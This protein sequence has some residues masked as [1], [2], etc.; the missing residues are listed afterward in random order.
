[1]QIHVA[2]PLCFAAFA[3]QPTAIL[4]TLTMSSKRDE[5]RKSLLEKDGV[6]LVVLS[7]VRS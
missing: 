2:I 3:R 7:S 5:M 6:V 1:M 4:I